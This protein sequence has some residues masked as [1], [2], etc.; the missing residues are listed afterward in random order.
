MAKV[1]MN[2]PL[3]IVLLII[4]FLVLG[5]NI[6]WAALPL[7]ILVLAEVFGIISGLFNTELEEMNKSNPKTPEGLKFIGDGLSRTGKALGKGEK[8]K[9]QGKKIKDT[10]DDFEKAG[11]AA[12]GFFDGIGKLF[13]K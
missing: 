13:K 6:I 7:G 9:M 11:D 2:L 5:K 3:M 8:A 1:L 10:R 4:F 12:D